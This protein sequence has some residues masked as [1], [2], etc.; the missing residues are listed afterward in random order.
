MA[1]RVELEGRIFTIGGKL[2]ASVRQDATIRL[3]PDGAESQFELLSRVDLKPGRYLVRY[4]VRSQDLNKT[5]SVYT[6][7]TVPDFS[8]APLALS[9]LVLSAT[10]SSKSAPAGALA[11]LI[12]VVPTTGRTFSTSHAVAAFLRVYQGG[13]GALQATDIEAVLTDGRGERTTIRTDRLTPEQFGT[14][15]AAE[16]TVAVPLSRLTAGPYLLTITA[17]AGETPAVTGNVRFS[18]R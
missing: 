7:V 11:A 3:V 10:P 17:T 14:R 4:S 13:K 1:D 16:Y 5:G 6:E 15:R 18:V 12:P 2:A 8:K 9:G